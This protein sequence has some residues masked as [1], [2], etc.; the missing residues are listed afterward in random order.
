MPIYVDHAQRRAELVAVAIDLIAENGLESA[1]VRSI[2]SRAGYSA[3]VVAHYFRNKA[4]LLRQAFDHTIE[5][6]ERRMEPLIA[7]GVDVVAALE[8]LLPTADFSRRTWKVWF[9]FWGVALSDLAYQQAQARRGREGREIIR[10][11]LDRCG[12]IPETAAGGREMQ[13]ERLLALIGG[14]ATIATF[15]PDLWDAERQRAI[16][17]SELAALR[18]GY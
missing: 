18:K 15:D 11:I 13:S 12:D 6:T 16:L 4:E 14:I 2:A 5:S 9:A 1:S 3:V 7:D 8:I 17:A 10:R